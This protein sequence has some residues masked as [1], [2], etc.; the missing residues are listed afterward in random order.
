[1]LE[2][3]FFPTLLQQ[4]HKGD[5][6]YKTSQLTH[7]VVKHLILINAKSEKL[8]QHQHKKP[9]IWNSGEFQIEGFL[10]WC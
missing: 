3:L 7:T 2:M 6:C 4:A 10:C 8:S 5:F 9:S 1:M